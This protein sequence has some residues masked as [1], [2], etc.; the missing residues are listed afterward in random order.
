[1]LFFGNSDNIIGEAIVFNLNSL[2]EGY[3]KLDIL[4]PPNNMGIYDSHEF[5]V[6]YFNYIFGNDITFKYF[7]DIIYN[8]YIGNDVYIIIDTSYDWAENIAEALFKVIQQRYGCNAIRINNFEDYLFA[9]NYNN[10]PL[11]N[12]QYGINNIDIDKER[13]T[14]IIESNNSNKY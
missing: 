6:A 11:F 4:M 1:M 5:D 2:K 7:F 13:Y 9:K 12:L 10:N 3:P 8:L 14:Y